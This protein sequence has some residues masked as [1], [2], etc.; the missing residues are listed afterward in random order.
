MF[1]IRRAG[2]AQLQDQLSDGLEAVADQLLTRCRATAPVLTG[3]VQQSLD[4][5][6]EHS[7]EWPKPAVFVS[8]SSGDGFFIHE[9]TS[10]T[11]AQPWMSQALDSM[12]RQIPSII[13][14]E[15]KGKEYGITRT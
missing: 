3:A 9:G 1:K 6:K 7:R 5:N 11:P 15:T 13:R 14:S 2:V 10:D 8:T 12:Q 4:T